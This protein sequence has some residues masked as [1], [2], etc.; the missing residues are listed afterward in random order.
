MTTIALAPTTPTFGHLRVPATA[1]DDVASAFAYLS[2]DSVERSLIDR[3]EHGDRSY[4]LV[5]AND[6]NDY[7]D[8]SDDTIHWDPHSALRVSGGTQSPAL[9]LGHEIDHAV[10][11]PRTEF[12]LA[13]SFDRQYDT[14]EERRVITGSERHAAQTL[15]EGIRYDHGGEPFR[16]DSPT[17]H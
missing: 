9:G 12:R 5:L 11:D 15:G 6:D 14:L 1:K 10:E 8:P 13:S 4:R 16:V 7:F 17:A 2:Q 3:L